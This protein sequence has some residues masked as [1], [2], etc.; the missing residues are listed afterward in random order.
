MIPSDRRSNVPRRALLWALLA[1]GLHAS[2]PAQEPTLFRPRSF[3]SGARAL[4][5]ADAYVADIHDVNAMYWNPAALPYMQNTSIVFNHTLD[6]ASNSMNENVATPLFA[7]KGEVVAVGLAVNHVGHVGKSS[8]GDFKAVQYGYD[9]AY[10][11]EVVPTLCV[12][13]AVNVRYGN[14]SSGSLWTFATSVGIFYAPAEGIS[15]GAVFGGLGNAVRY[16]YDGTATLL[17]SERLPRD[18]QVGATMQFPAS[19]RKTFVTLSIG[20]EKVFGVTGLRYKGGAE[21]VFLRLVAVRFGYIVDPDVKVATY[22][23]G[24][25]AGK[26]QLDYGMLPSRLTDRLYQ[27]TLSYDLWSKNESIRTDR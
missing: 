8:T 17:S 19:A 16:T 12:G 13:G 10:A 5:F 6:R 2:L 4:G 18:L 1:L 15:Y 3:L 7:R 24:L 26:W 9:V 23:L 21:Y 20:N 27:F 22:G 11:N 14:A 25:H